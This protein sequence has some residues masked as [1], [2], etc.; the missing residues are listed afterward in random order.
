MLST[1]IY[2][3]PEE[4]R[5]NYE[6]MSDDELEEYLSLREQLS[7]EDHM[8]LCRKD[9]IEFLK[10]MEPT[11]MVGG[12]HKIMGDKFNELNVSGNKR[13]IINIAP[14][15][16][17]SFLTSQFLPAWY[18]GNNPKAYLMSISNT[19]ELA[20]GFGRKVRDIVSSERFQEVFPDVKV[21]S[22]SKSAGRW[23]VEQGGELFAAGVG[24]SVT[25]RG[26]DLLI[27]DDPYTEQCMLQPS[28]FDDVWE[29][30]QAGPRQRLM[31]GGN[32][33]VVHTRWSTKDLTGMLVKEQAKNPDADKWEL[34]EFPAIMPSGNVLWPEFWTA[35][36]LK[37]VQNSIAP[38]LWNAQWLQNPTS[39]EGAL[40]KREWWNR[41]QFENP[42]SCDYIIQSYDTAF[43][44]RDTAD[45]SVISTWGIW[46]PDGEYVINREG[47]KKLFD[48]EVPH[49]ILLDVVKDRFEFPELK[50]K[51]IYLYNYWEPDS[52]IIE[53]KASGMSLSQEFRYI[54]IPVQEYSPGR[55]QD[56]VARVNSVSDLFASGFIWAP[57]KR[58]ADEMIDEVQAFPTGDHD[59]QVDSMT[60]ALMRFRQGGFIRLDSDWRDEY[61][62][63]RMRSYY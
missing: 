19:T 55:G 39:E 32:I 29:Y 23:A 13:I 20:V 37:K 47:E 22:D 6:E 63:R 26:A 60:L 42:P 59:D 18:I 14:R 61:I 3:S 41:W 28:V 24:A 62:P 40:I 7:H 50:Q 5:V 21:R 12:H 2:T 54:G 43:S 16:G 58:F 4:L 30:Y 53:A 38:H 44:K 48:G 15:H 56:K 10:Y 51:A 17:K 25:G 36:A 49:V 11:V 46:Y 45:Y 34:I 1:D 52:V 35:D 8:E 27:I 57:E 33:L 9:F 31:P